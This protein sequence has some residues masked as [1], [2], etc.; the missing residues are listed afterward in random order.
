MPEPTR[1]VDYDAR[2]VSID[3]VRDNLDDCL[4]IVQSG[5]AFGITWHDDQEESDVVAVLIGIEEWKGLVE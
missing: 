5:G 1:G 2:V 3:Y 4:R